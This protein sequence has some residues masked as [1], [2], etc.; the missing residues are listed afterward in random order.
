MNITKFL[1]MTALLWVSTTQVALAQAWLLC[2]SC[3]TTADYESVALEAVP[4]IPN[5]SYY[6]A[7]ANTQTGTFHYVEVIFHQREGDVPASDPSE[8][9]TLSSSQSEGSLSSS[10]SD[11]SLSFSVGSVEASSE[12]RTQFSAIVQLSRNEILVAAPPGID[13]LESFHGAQPEILGPYLWVKKSAQNP[14]WQSGAIGSSWVTGLWNALKA[15][16]GKGPSACI[17]FQNGDSACYQLNPL[18]KNAPRYING[19]AKTI[20][21]QPLEESGGIGGGTALEIY[22]PDPG[23]YAWGR[24]SFPTYSLWLFCSYSGGELTGCWTQIIQDP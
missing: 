1:C 5:S 18:D 8:P 7:V 16:D 17:V 15:A 6:F 14:A 24:S 3:S 9:Y 23:V 11:G 4:A 19:T 22:N 20:N 12:E 2:D 21:G 13:G 10:Q